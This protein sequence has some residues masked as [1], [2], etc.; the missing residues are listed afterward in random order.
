MNT[1]KNGPVGSSIDSGSKI[2]V[3][4]KDT[5]I[6]YLDFIIGNLFIISI[7]KLYQILFH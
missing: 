3:Y 1:D 6:L 5:T 4:C 2:R 7:P